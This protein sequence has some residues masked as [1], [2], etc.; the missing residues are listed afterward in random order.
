[1]LVCTYICV[2]NNNQIYQCYM[3]QSPLNTTQLLELLSVAVIAQMHTELIAQLSAIKSHKLQTS[4]SL[5][6]TILE[7][8]IELKKAQ[9]TLIG[10]L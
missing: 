2:V 3:T 6:L 9:I 5:Q 8:A 1:M 10:N 4:V 7:R